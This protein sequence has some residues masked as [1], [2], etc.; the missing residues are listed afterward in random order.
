[1]VRDFTKVNLDNAD[2]Q[3]ASDLMGKLSAEIR[4]H[5]WDLVFESPTV[6]VRSISATKPN[7]PPPGIL[8]SCKQAYYEAIKL[9]WSNSTFYIF[10]PSPHRWIANIGRRRRELLKDVRVNTQEPALPAF[11][12]ASRLMINWHDQ[13]FEG[14]KLL[15]DCQAGKRGVDAG[16]IKVKLMFREHHNDATA[17][18]T[19]WT[20]NPNGVA[21]EWVQRVGGIVSFG[22]PGA[23]MHHKRK[24]A[25]HR[26]GG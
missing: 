11:K 2:P 21:L 13:L 19:V 5:I 6:I 16:V 8:L 17:V 14:E 24:D 3:T 15:E 12:A 9:H 1:M 20:S 25:G 26:S 10:G 23:K 18:T 22:A 7:T 4:N